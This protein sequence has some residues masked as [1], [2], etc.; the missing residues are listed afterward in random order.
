MRLS[1]FLDKNRPIIYKGDG[2][3]SLGNIKDYIYNVMD[4]VHK[5][6]NYPLNVYRIYDNIATKF[7]F[8]TG[9]D[10]SGYTLY[11]D[12]VEYYLI[13]DANGYGY[14]SV[15]YFKARLKL[16]NLGNIHYTNYK[17]NIDI[18]VQIFREASELFHR[19]E[20]GICII[21]W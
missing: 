12:G 3:N 7:V 4:N 1:E 21:E 6:E 10:Y 20:W 18:N 13:T 16:M 9:Y 19:L 8:Q 15:F 14:P 11:S 5:K 2:F 17:D